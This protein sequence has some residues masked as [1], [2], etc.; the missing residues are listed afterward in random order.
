MI[1][2]NM[3]SSCNKPAICYTSKKGVI[4]T[5]TI[6]KY[7]PATETQKTIGLEDIIEREYSGQGYIY[8]NW[9]A[10]YGNDWTQ[11]CYIPELNDTTY[12]H[13]DFLELCDDNEEIARDIFETVDWQSPGT[14]IDEYFAN[15]ELAACGH[16]ARMFFCYGKTESPC[17]NEPYKNKTV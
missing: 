5:E 3:Q 6:G 11:V 14:L 4:M 16:C 10:Y 12:T 8:K 9:E 17:C 15:G 2:G 7:I 13:A 1:K